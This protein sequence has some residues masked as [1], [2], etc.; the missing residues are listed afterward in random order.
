VGLKNVACARKEA[1]MISRQMPT[2]SWGRQFA[3]MAAQKTPENERF[4]GRP[5]CRCQGN[6]LRSRLGL[7][8]LGNGTGNGRPPDQQILQGVV[9]LVDLGA[10]ILKS[11]AL[12]PHGSNPEPSSPHYVNRNRAHR[13]PYC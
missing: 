6:A 1:A 7:F 9:D 4:P 3:L 10:E 13:P 2:T 11:A 5:Q 8:H 12:L